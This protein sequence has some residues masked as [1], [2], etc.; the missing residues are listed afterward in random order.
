MGPTPW[1]VLLAPFPMD[2]F[3]KGGGG[4]FGVGGDCYSFII[5][6]ILLPKGGTSFLGSGEGGPGLGSYFMGG[7]NFYLV[8]HLKTFFFFPPRWVRGDGD[9]VN[10]LRPGAPFGGLCGVDFFPWG[11][12][13]CF[14]GW[15]KKGGRFLSR[16]GVGGAFW[17]RALFSPSSPGKENFRNPTTS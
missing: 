15:G 2:P 13:I 6:K 10:F 14:M 7:I 16:V 12:G 5:Q 3:V 9:W 8:F 11:W 4:I 1:G 17:G